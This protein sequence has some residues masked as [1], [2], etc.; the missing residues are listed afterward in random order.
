M[1]MYNLHSLFVIFISYLSISI[2]YIM[3][4][5][6]WLDSYMLNEDDFPTTKQC[7]TCANTIV[8]KYSEDGH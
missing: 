8:I 1:S 2:R 5:V 6:S 4:T 7:T 3:K